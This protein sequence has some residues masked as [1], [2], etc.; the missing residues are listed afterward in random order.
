MEVLQLKR[1]NL[2][3]LIALITICTIYFCACKSEPEDT[4]EYITQSYSGDIKDIFELTG[5]TKSTGVWWSGSSTTYVLYYSQTADGGWVAWEKGKWYI[6][7]PENV[8]E[9][10]IQSKGTSK[11]LQTHKK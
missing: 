11:I 4:T 2:C 9:K 8:G 10:V 3:I 6:Y 7:T 5:T 1:K